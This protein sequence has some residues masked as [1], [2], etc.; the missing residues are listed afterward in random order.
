MELQ[1]IPSQKS[2]YDEMIKQI[3]EFE[4]YWFELN[5]PPADSQGGTT[6]K[7]LLNKILQNRYNSIG[8]FR[9]KT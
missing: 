5:A 2:L 7:K 8:A 3:S 6:S 1:G 4:G 9:K